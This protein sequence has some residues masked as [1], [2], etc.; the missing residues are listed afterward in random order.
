TSPNGSS[1]G[2]AGRAPTSRRGRWRSSPRSPGGWPTARSPVSSTSRRRRSRPISCTSSP[3]WT[4][5]RGPPRS[6]GPGRRGSC[7]SRSPLDRLEPVAHPAHRE[8]ALGPDLRAKGADEDVDDVGPGVEV[9]VP[10][11]PEQLLTGEHLVRVLD[12]GL[13]EGVL[14]GGELDLAAGHEGGAA[15][16]VE[17]EVA[18]GQGAVAGRGG[19]PFAQPEADPGEELGELE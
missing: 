1:P 5:T 8:D 11:H 19:T 13:E 2:W 12:E 18:R 3:S 15:A 4:S 16:H 17:A 7:R 9:H 6:P 10:D 14:P